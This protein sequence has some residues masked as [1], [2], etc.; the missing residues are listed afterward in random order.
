MPWMCWSNWRANGA[1][2]RPES[3]KPLVRCWHPGAGIRTSVLQP[4]FPSRAAHEAESDNWGAPCDVVTASSR[5]RQEAV[6]RRRSR[7][8]VRLGIS[9]WRASVSA[10]FPFAQTTSKLLT[11]KKTASL[12][13]RLRRDWGAMRD[14]GGSRDVVTASSRARQE[15]VLRRRSRERVR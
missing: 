2:K 5:A 14:C 11:H 9:A 15:A 6:L 12:R 7:E 3:I 10:R 4:A 8:R 1:E 13:A